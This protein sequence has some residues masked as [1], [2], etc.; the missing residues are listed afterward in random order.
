[1]TSEEIYKAILDLLPFRV[2]YADEDMIERFFNQASVD[3]GKRKPSD[4]GRHLFDCHKPESRKMIERMY[5]EFRAG[6][7]EPFVKRK[8]KN[9]RTKVVT[10]YPAVVEGKFKGIV[11]TIIYPDD[12]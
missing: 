11:E 4:I 3:S 8:V 10:W 1:M 2:E 12:I 7:R 5:R 6:R 9:G